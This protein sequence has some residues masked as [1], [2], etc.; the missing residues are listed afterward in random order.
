MAKSEW[1]VAALLTA[2][3]LA[4]CNAQAE[5][6]QKNELESPKQAQTKGSAALIDDPN[7]PK[8]TQEWLDSTSTRIH[9]RQT[10]DAIIYYS[11]FV[12]ID[13]LNK[14]VIDLLNGGPLEVGYPY[15]DERMHELLP[16]EFIELTTNENR[17]SDCTMLVQI[18]KLSKAKKLDPKTERLVTGLRNKLPKHPLGENCEE[19]DPWKGLEKSWEE[20]VEVNGSSAIYHQGHL[21][22]IDPNLRCAQFVTEQS[23]SFEITPQTKAIVRSYSNRKPTHMRDSYRTS[24]IAT[25]FE[26]GVKQG[27]S[28]AGRPQIQMLANDYIADVPGVI[29]VDYFIIDDNQADAFCF[30]SKITQGSVHSTDVLVTPREGKKAEWTDF[31]DNRP[32]WKGMVESRDFGKVVG[33]SLANETA[34]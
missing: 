33:A 25:M 28:R 24:R 30:V 7:A 23:G 16:I 11:D 6:A 2:V 1:I 34:R 21:T 13:Q 26:S 15:N 27:L 9:V 17:P 4:G 20:L 5:T 12:R 32:A 18:A 3:T 10:E 19:Q 14:Q 8:S 22:V 29:R 31:V